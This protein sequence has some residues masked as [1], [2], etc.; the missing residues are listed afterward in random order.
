V[1]P[2]NLLAIFKR[3]MGY[4]KVMKVLGPRVLILPNPGDNVIE[5]F[6]IPEDVREKKT[7]GVI[8]CIGNGVTTMGTVP[9]DGVSEGDTVVYSKF[10]G[11]EIVLDSITHIIVGVDDL[12]MILNNEK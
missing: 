9:M 10:V 2:Y 12:M 11:T 8:K 6:I 7:S 4:L 5:G 1:K 3:K